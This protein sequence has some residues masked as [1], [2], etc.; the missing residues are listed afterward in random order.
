MASVLAHGLGFRVQVRRQKMEL[1]GCLMLVA[2][3]I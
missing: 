1:Y 3:C 2:H